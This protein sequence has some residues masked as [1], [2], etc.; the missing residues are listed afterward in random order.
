MPA[1]NPKKT[2]TSLTP[3]DAAHLERIAP[4]FDIQFHEAGDGTY[5]LNALD[6]S[7]GHEVILPAKVAHLRLLAEICAR[8]A[9][10][11]H[12]QVGVSC[13]D[14]L[15]RDQSEARLSR[16]AELYGR[17]RDAERLR[18]TGDGANV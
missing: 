17:D 16:V 9:K 7:G 5:L 11:V 4:M 1:R 2:F 8:A 18:A 10:W 6:G 13:Y 3:N 14:S 15:L 12:F